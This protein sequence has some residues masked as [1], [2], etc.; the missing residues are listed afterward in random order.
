METD[1]GDGDDKKLKAKTKS[2]ATTTQ[3]K[4]AKLVQAL[5]SIHED[6]DG[7]ATDEE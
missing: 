5:E 1:D 3:N 4:K 7:M 6:E 2:T